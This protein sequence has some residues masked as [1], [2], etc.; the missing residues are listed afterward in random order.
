MKLELKPF[1]EN[2]AREI[3]CELDEARASI[4]KGKL[5]AVILSAH[6]GSG[7][8]ITLAQ[9][10]DLMFGGGDGIP[11]RP[12]TTFLWLSD[13]PELNVQSGN[14]LLGACDLLPYYKMVRIENDV[15]DDDYLQPGYLYFIN[16]QLLGKDKLLTKD[17]GDRRKFT[18]WQT[19]TNTIARAPQDFVLIIDEAHRGATANDKNRTTIMQKFIVGSESDRLSPVPLVLG[20]SAT[21]QRFT[22]LLGN[23]NRTQRPVNISAD[24]VRSSGLLKDW[25]VVRHPKTAVAGD[26]TLLESAT[27]SWKHFTGLWERYCVQEKEKDIVRPILIV[28]IEDGS[29]NSLTRTPLDDVVRVIERHS[30]PLGINEIVHCLQDHT[31]LEAGGRIIRKLEASRIQESQDI[32]VVIFKTALSTGW[33]CPRAEVMMSFRRAQDQTS[34]AQLVGRMIRT[35]LAR[36]IGSNEALDTVEL[37]LPHYDAEA[38]EAVLERLRNPDAQDGV[39]T[40]VETSV[41]IYARNSAMEKIF[42]ILGN[43]PTYSVDRLPRMSDVKRALRLA[44]LLVH[45]GVDINADEH[46]REELVKKLKGLR[47][48]CATERADWDTLIREG[49]E[50]HVDV[51]KIATGGMQIAGK[52]SIRVSLVEENIDQLFDDAGRILASGE[53]LH[54]TYW[55][56][57]HDRGYPNQAKLELFAILNQ[58][59]TLLVM[60]RLSKQL[61]DAMWNKHKAAIQQ[62][63]AS[64]RKRFQSL[65]QA[66]GEAA[67]QDWELPTQIVEKKEGDV[68]EKHLYCT[69]S[70]G[71]SAKLDGW[72]K[73]F[74]ELEM[75]KEGFVGWLRNLPRREWALCIPYELAGKR[76]FYPDFIIVRKYGKGLVVDVVEP[77]D[78]SR[79]DTWA[80]AKGL[81]EFADKHGMDFGQ[82]VIARRK[83][84]T[85]HM[86]DVNE[87]RTRAKAR[88]MQSSSDLES[89]FGA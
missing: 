37:Y 10:I 48:K 8:T 42:A 31:D 7:K 67:L 19:V 22:T 77:H 44:G 80:K 35:P 17:P 60:E 49:G 26:L 24:D 27:K 74:L 83:D 69:T 63:S 45:E 39:P 43:L 54:R 72:E 3:I 89:L 29:V 33:D 13:S 68:W 59:E 12:Q 16:T 4:A 30:G 87:M 76:P 81:A 9:V 75:K 71:F 65:I 34:I 18:F 70:G 88:K 5:Q 36:R 78:D 38:L 85:W 62:M 46:T 64:T 14:K 73:E 6:T 21:P 50:I 28:Q 55:K 41:E 79:T 82:L 20:M 51:S 61:F 47:D 56:R 57:Y 2:A 66:A 1:Q 86:A 23:T 40:R 52:T 32:K 84:K 25:I 53:G 11:A 15:F 58:P